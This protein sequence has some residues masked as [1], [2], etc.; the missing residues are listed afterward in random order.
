MR[1]FLKRWITNSLTLVVV[2]FLL[3]DRVILSG[4]SAAFMAA[5]LL[6]VVNALLRPI[7]LFFTLPLNIFTFGLFTLVIN[8]MMLGIVSSMVS[9]FT[10]RGG[11]GSTTLVALI[12][13]AVSWL[14]GGIFKD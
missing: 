5:A 11:F 4:P 14:I 3:G 9:G 10:I 13:S 12:L 2:A 6:G 8:G 7:L 1:G